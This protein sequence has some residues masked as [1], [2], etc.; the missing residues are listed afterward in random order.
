[1][2]PLGPPASNRLRPD[3]L[4]RSRRVSSFARRGCDVVPQTYL[5]DFSQPDQCSK[6]PHR[7][8]YFTSKYIAICAYDDEFFVFSPATLLSLLFINGALRT[9]LR[10]RCPFDSIRNLRSRL[11]IPWRVRF[12]VAPW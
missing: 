10:Y 3:I 4:Q 1:L 5:Y 2:V 12:K 11:L 6:L 7:F 8:V 9:H